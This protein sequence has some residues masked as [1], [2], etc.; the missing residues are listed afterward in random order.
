MLTRILARLGLIR[1]DNYVRGQL[2][3]RRAIQDNM[4]ENMLYPAPSDRQWY[5][6]SLI[7][8]GREKH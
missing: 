3:L 6:A 5:T 8:H 4:A 2:F 7:A 1:T